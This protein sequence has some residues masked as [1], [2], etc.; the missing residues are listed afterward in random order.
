MYK[1]TNINTKKTRKGS[2]ISKKSVEDQIA[3]FMAF[4]TCGSQSPIP[5]SESNKLDESEL[6]HVIAGNS[7]EISIEDFL[8]SKGVQRDEPSAKRHDYFQKKKS[9]ISD[10]TSPQNKQKIPSEQFHFSPDTLDLISSPL[11]IRRNMTLSISDIPQLSKQTS[12]QDPKST[13]RPFTID[14]EQGISI[15]PRRSPSTN[16]RMNK[17]LDF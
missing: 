1:A 10:L 14:L 12:L 16:Q 15:H 3:E 6:G 7:I 5:L 8:A 2:K 17:K 11:S 9:T 13:P 4:E